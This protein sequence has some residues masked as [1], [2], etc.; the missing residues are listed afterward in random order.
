LKIESKI[1]KSLIGLLIAGQIAFSFSF[2]L[3]PKRAEAFLGIGDITFNTE[4]GNVYDILKDVG[5][6]AAQRIAIQYANKYLSQFVDKLIDKYRIKDYLAYDKVLS[7][8]YLNQY[9]YKN[10]DDPDLRA[11]YGILATDVNT[12]VTVTDSSGKKM[13]AIAALKQKLDKYYYNQGGINSSIIYSRNAYIKNEDYFLAAQSYFSYPPSFSQQELYG[14]FGDMITASQ[15][16]SQQEIASSNGLKN[17]RSTP[18]GIVPH[19]CVGAGSVIDDSSNNND[20]A[21]NDGSDSIP[22]D[23]FGEPSGFLPGQSNLSL[24]SRTLVALGVVQKASAA[25]WDSQADCEAQGGT[26]KVDANGL[27][28]S[29]IQNPS[30]FI[31]D[32]ATNAINSIF[33]ANFGIRDN[34]Y[35]TIGSLLGNFIFTKLSLHKA[36]GVLSEDNSS[37]DPGTNETATIKDIDIDGDGISD[38]QDSDG[39]GQPD[40]CIY[41]GVP[42]TNSDGSQVSTVGPPCL[43]SAEALTS[44]PQAASNPNSGNGL[45]C[46]PATQTVQVGQSTTFTA[47][48][49][50][51]VYSWS[52]NDAT[53]PTGTG[54]TFSTVWNVASDAIGKSVFLSDSAGGTARCQVIIQ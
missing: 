23:G 20:G 13:P 9:I 51:G 14:Q 48:G 42:E 2:M 22:T 32:F 26:W 44:H 17:D 33:S 39:D 36:G 38:G 8:Y 50:N 10:V 29:A 28:Q 21:P 25:I 49:G 16:A 1:T 41:G 45:A 19:A 47:T 11:I 46:A 18:A 15:Q 27:A 53:P 30:A 6:G 31:H 24:I 37:Y 52:Q 54:S 43:G 40:F 5:L 35:T 4:I 12:R 7:G 3:V 34:I